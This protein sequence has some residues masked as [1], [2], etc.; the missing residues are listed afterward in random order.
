[1]HG[2]KQI[3]SMSN[4]N[5]ANSNQLILIALLA[6]LGVSPIG[7]PHLI[8][9]VNWV[10]GGAVGMEPMDWFDFA[11]HGGALLISVILLI[12]VIYTSLL[13]SK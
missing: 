9:K 10:A 13:K 1:M 2:K 12:R 5:S 3:L 11:M 6:F 8:G 7:D 4:K